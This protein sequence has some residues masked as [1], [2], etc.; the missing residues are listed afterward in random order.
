MDDNSLLNQKIAANPNFSVWVSA[1]AGTGKTTVLVNRLLRLF[2][3]DVEPSKVLCLT[4]TN[5]GAI[6]MQNRIY[7]KTLDW[8]TIPDEDLK[9]ELNNL[10]DD[11]DESFDFDELFSK[12]RKLFSKLIDNPMPL[13][14]Y[15]IHAFCQSILKR[16]PI[17]ACI[18]PHFKIIEDS[19]VK[20][21]LNEAY[22]KL[23]H[24]LKNDKT[25]DYVDVFKSFTYLM[26]NT[27]EIEFDNLVE[28]IVDGREHFFEL[29]QKYK[30]KSK[31]LDYLKSK[32]FGNSQYA[33]ESFLNDINLFKAN[34]LD[35]IPSGFIDNLKRVLSVDNGKK[36]LARLNLISTFLQEKNISK[37]FDVYKKIFLN[38]DDSIP[39]DCIL[40]KKSINEDIKFVDNVSRETIRIRNAVEFINSIEIYNATSSVLDI[41]LTLNTIYEGLKKKR[42]VMDFTD[43]ITTVKNLFDKDNISSWIL[44]KLDGGISHVLID[45][46]QD[47]SPIQWEIVDKLTEEFFTSGSDKK[48]V[49]S[50]FSVGDRKQSIFSFQGA[51]IKLFEK[52]KNH[53]K[54]RIEFENYPFFDLPLNRSFR[55]CK[56]ILNTVDDVIKNSNGVLLPN[57]D[58][59]HIPNRKDSFGLVEVLPLVKSIEDET[60]KCFK[61]PIENINVFNTDIEMANVLATKIKY[62]LD[63]EY[64]SDSKNDEP[65]R[66]RKIEPKDIMILVRKRNLVDNI[67]R[68]LLAKNIPLAGRDKLSLSDNIA[69]E[70]LISLLKF[71]LFNYDDLSLAEVLKSPLYNLTDDDL[72]DLCFNRKDETLYSMLCKSEKYKDISDDLKY[73]IDFSKTALPFE[74]FDYILKVQ[75]KRKNFIS[76]LGIEV[77]DILNGFLSQCLSYDNLKLGKSLS[78]FY[79]W[80]SLNEVEVKRNM[81]QVNNTV[82]IMTV[83]SSKGL[84]APVVFIYNANAVLSSSRDRII[85]NEDFP[86]YKTSNFKNS[87]KVFSDMIENNNNANQEE[88][89]RLLY[90]AMTRARDR[91]YVIGSENKSKDAKTWYSCIKESL[92]SNPETK[93]NNDTKTNFTHDVFVND[94]FVVLGENETGDISNITKSSV[95]IPLNLPEFFDKKEDDIPSFSKNIDAKS[96]LSQ[97]DKNEN[98]SLSRGTIIHKLLEHISKFNGEDVEKFIDFYLSKTQIEDKNLIKNNIL[99]LYNNP[100]YNFIF[101]SNNLS[102]TE[103]ITSENGT[104]QILRVDK[105]VFDN[106]DIWIIDYK[107]DKQTDTV[108]SSYR[109]QL[110][111]Y[112]DAITKIYPNKK[113][114]IAI[115]WINDLKFSEII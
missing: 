6:E 26:Q 54:E 92:L 105:V 76:R 35:H 85:W 22:Q 45:E 89:Y 25:I 67:T 109:K 39:K 66:V 75:N 11:K 34:I 3:N 57:E 14:I 115:L 4:Y 77:I 58:I 50:L 82:R 15:T 23:I 2:L 71:V 48:N 95:E 96:P 38:S 107:T 94:E 97:Y 78:D 40:N 52:Y 83:H 17:E 10:L 114:H 100:E 16:F 63:N 79:E 86:M 108:P 106:D 37:K 91:L 55:S 103:I 31:M 84:E 102:E 65:K 64:I 99:E 110:E 90:V 73:L 46:A 80:F 59:T 104:S 93:I 69:I 68:A 81:E 29:C 27:P 98:S 21:L 88:F 101:N 24:T 51:N 70:D 111:K 74:F 60:K 18:T 47:T 44:Y 112:K 62:L 32:I 19:E 8:A 53:F 12:A 72:F 5:A 56:N 41:G 9:K 43:L 1:S 36:S 42:G 33:N 7:K 87:G 49:K 61:P 113:I 13:K 30:T 20:N 28:T